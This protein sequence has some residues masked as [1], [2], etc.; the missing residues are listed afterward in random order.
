[1]AQST[2]AYATL[3]AAL[4]IP[5]AAAAQGS[6]PTA[7]I[8]EAL[9][10][11]RGGTACEIGAGDGELSIAVAQQVGAQG[12]VYTSELGDERI[13]AL[14]AKVSA[15]GRPQI[16]VMG[17]SP[18]RTNFPDAAC[19]VLFMRNVYHHFDTPAVMNASMAAAL[20]PGGRL[21]IADFTPEREAATPADRDNDSTHGVT[22]ATVR[23][24]LAA[25]GFSVT[26]T[27]GD[28]AGG[29]R[30]FIVLATRGR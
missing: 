28:S 26:A 4:L 5:S 1:M 21:V 24:E 22:P 23:R 14:Q 11:P 25:A 6:L 10:V 2:P 17:G 16:H 12:H 3:I 7:Q 9:A 30:P 18:Q 27:R 8:L 19:D 20:R 15:A 13:D 29:D